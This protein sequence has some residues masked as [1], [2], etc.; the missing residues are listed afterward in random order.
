MSE[1]AKAVQEVAK[2]AGKGLDVV[3]GL[4][5]FF[6]RVFG[7]LIEN[8][9]GL[10]TDKLQYY[11]L[12]KA[13]LLHQKTEQKLKE[14]GVITTKLVSPK[15]GIPL[16]EAAALEEEDSIHTKWANM[17]ANAMDPSYTTQIK[18]SY[19]S[20]LGD[21]E[22][23][24][25]LILDQICKEYLNLSDDNKK[26]MLFVKAKLAQF[27]RIS[28]DQCDISLRNL[29][30]LGCVRPGVVTNSNISMGGHSPS[31]YKDTELVGLTTLGLDF[32]KAISN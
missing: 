9:V 17:L 10:A 25:V 2:T 32:F 5:K 16:I 18:R 20:I 6:T 4:G 26:V 30:R 15:L 21:M 19:V 12:E 8:G 13:I 11:R 22:P 7:S 27:F 23:I 28:E 14:R 1:E 24:D 3:T 29:M 31:S